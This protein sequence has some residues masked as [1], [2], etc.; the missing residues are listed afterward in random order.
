MEWARPYL[1][2]KRKVLL[3]V[4]GRINS[5]YKP[6]EAVRMASIAVQCISFEPKSRPTMDQVV[7]ALVQLQN[8]LVKPANVDQPGKDTN[9]LEGLIT[10]DKYQKNG[11][12]E[13]VGCCCCL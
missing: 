2:S 10:E 11:I 5:Q 12:K 1:T 4:D 6:E 3:M 9:K 8:S 7:R 13:K